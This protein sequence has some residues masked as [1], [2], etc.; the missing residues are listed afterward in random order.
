VPLRGQGQRGRAEQIADAARAIERR[1]ARAGGSA[2]AA[3]AALAPREPAA[4]LQQLVMAP[5][6]LG[7]TGRRTARRLSPGAGRRDASVRNEGP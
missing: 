1:E 4:R 7:Q 3:I 6:P 2:A 5:L